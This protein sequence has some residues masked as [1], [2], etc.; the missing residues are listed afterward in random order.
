MLD[1]MENKRDGRPLKRGRRRP[2]SPVRHLKTR[3]QPP[4]SSP[5][6]A[7]EGRKYCA[8]RT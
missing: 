3:R 8:A 7:V 6:Y 5:S 1:L 4:T 2:R